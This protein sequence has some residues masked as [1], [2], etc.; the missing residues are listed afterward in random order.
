MEATSRTLLPRILL[1]SSRVMSMSPPSRW[2]VMLCSTTSLNS[3][4]P[5]LSPNTPSVPSSISCSARGRYATDRSACRRPLYIHIP[6]C[7]H[8]CSYCD[9]AKVYYRE[10]FVLKYLERLKE[11]LDALAD[12]VVYTGPI[13][14]YFDYKLGTLEYR[15]VRF[16][17]ETLD[18]PNFQGNAAVNYT[19]RETPWTRIIEHKW[20]EFGKDDEGND[21]PKTVISREYS[22]ESAGVPALPSVLGDSGDGHGHAEKCGWAAPVGYQYAG[23]SK[24][25]RSQRGAGG[26]RGARPVALRPVWNAPEAPENCVCA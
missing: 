2:L 13:D 26:Q 15:S 16:E 12:K 4:L 22:A 21:L 11:E 7:D 1:Y 25:R 14:A 24:S 3:T 6:F 20:F 10:E 5:N 9:F 18:K 23:A 8:I 19:D 17:N